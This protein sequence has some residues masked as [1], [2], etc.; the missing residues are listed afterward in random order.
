MAIDAL[1]NEHVPVCVGRR[2]RVRVPGLIGAIPSYGHMAVGISRDPGEYVRLSGLGRFPSYFD[3]R[4]PA[5]PVIGRER[6]IDVSVIR[7]GGVYVP[8]VVH[9]DSGEQIAETGPRRT[10]RPR[11]ATENLVVGEGER[12][13]RDAHA[14][15]HGY[16][17]SIQIGAAVI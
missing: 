4:R 17:G 16:V 8:E 9:R 13:T 2:D 15:R 1:R 6:V 12:G 10:R 11:P 3:G 5:R 14:R 7:P